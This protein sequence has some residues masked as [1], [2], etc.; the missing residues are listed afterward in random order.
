VAKALF[1]ITAV[2]EALNSG[3]IILTPNRRLCNQIRLAMVESQTQTTSISTILT[4]KVF[5]FSEWAESLWQQL[6]GVDEESNKLIINDLQRQ[7]I[8]RQI[9]KKDKLS[10]TGAAASNL[11]KQASEAYQRLQLWELPITALDSP[12]DDDKSNNGKLINWVQQFE[13]HLDRIQAITR[14][15]ANKIVIDAFESGKL[16]KESGIYLQSF[17]VVPPLYKKLIHLASDNISISPPLVKTENIQQRCAALDKKQEVRAVAAWSRKILAEKPDAK[18]GIVTPNLG[19]HRDLIERIF[20]ETFEPQYYSIDTPRYTLPFNISTGTPLGKTPLIN[21]TLLLLRLNQH[22]ITHEQCY[23]ILGS[24]FFSAIDDENR[25]RCDIARQL[26]K[27]KQFTFRTA[28]IRNAAEKASGS[29]QSN[30][31]KTETESSETKSQARLTRCLLDFEEFRRRNSKPCS[32]EVWVQRFF[33]QLECLQWPGPRK[34]DSVEFQQVTQWHQLLEKFLSLDLVQRT[35]S[36]S[37]AFSALEQL[38]NATHF[39]AE[40]KDSPIQI[41][42]MLEGVGLSFSHCWVLGLD[43]QTWPQKLN[44]NPLL[45]LSLQRDH[46][47]PQSSLENELIYAQSLTNNYLNCADHVVISYS[48]DDQEATLLPSPLIDELNEKPLLDFVSLKDYGLAKHRDDIPLA[49]F[50]LVDCRFGPEYKQQNADSIKGGFGILKQQAQCPFNAFAKY[51]LG[52][53]QS[54]AP[55][56]GLSAADKGNIIHAVLA[57]IWQSLN[58]SATL[59]AS[60]DEKLTELIGDAVTSVFTK[61]Y[62]DDSEFLDQH[63]YDLEHKR[64]ERLAWEWLSLEKNRIDFS[65]LDIEKELKVDF[66]GLP[67]TLRIDRI[68]QLANGEKI[69]IDYKTGS[70]TRATWAGERPDEPQLPLYAVAL[71]GDP[72]ENGKKS[73]ENNGEGNGEG[74]VKGIAFAIIKTKASDFFGVAETSGE[75]KDKKLSLPNKAGFAQDWQNTLQEFRRV[76]LNL[77]KEFAQGSCSVDFKKNQFNSYDTELDALNRIAEI[78]FINEWARES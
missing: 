1:D 8:W 45:P 54:E 56:L 3:A 40:V 42:G 13:K 73:G 27:K 58:D 7:H 46:K 75:N 2:L 77:S 17:D 63:Y 69:L 34:L 49:K 74:K 19:S 18:I 24:P 62:F 52:T 47:M 9:I 25:I 64:F 15:N 14:E 39:Q 44:P 66:G 10:V 32:I 50:E 35:W 51:R 36:F 21:D 28:E 38:A 72:K 20:C 12:F 48:N 30:D 37:E 23:Q 31:T 60:S 57:L 78:D 71:D 22:K 33:S 61:K 76:L 53:E 55:S 4:P 26:K 5:N 41:L 68:D 43:S 67:L 11:A 16:T 65:V 70:V 59:N 6:A 29:I